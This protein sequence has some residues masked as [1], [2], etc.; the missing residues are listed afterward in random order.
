MVDR[1]EAAEVERLVE[2][3][4]RRQVATER[5][6]AG[7]AERARQRA[8]GLRRETERTAPVAVAHQHSFDGVA[9]GGQEQRLHR[10]VTRGALGLDGESRERHRGGQLLAEGARQIGHRLVAAG[11]AR[12]PVPHLA[13]AVHGLAA[14]AQRR[15][16]EREVHAGHGSGS[17]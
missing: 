17:L 12:R 13:G 14:L 11:T 6:L 15:L 1:L 4:R 8:A 5:H 2:D 10:A 16:E 7:R 3:L 9:V